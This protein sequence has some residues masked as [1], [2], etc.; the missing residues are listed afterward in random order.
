MRTW[1]TRSRGYR[2][3]CSR[4]SG[5]RARLPE[6]GRV[7]GPA[8]VSELALDAQVLNRI[9]GHTESATGERIYQGPNNERV[10]AKAAEARRSM[11]A[12]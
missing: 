9:S 11:R 6:G 4:C 3:R 10:R 7:Q 5:D 1:R 2:S 8:L 12:F